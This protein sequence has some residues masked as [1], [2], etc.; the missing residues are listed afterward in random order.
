ML[1]D[2]DGDRHEMVALSES[3]DAPEAFSFNTEYFTG[4]CSGGYLHPYRTAYRLDGHGIPERRLRERDWKSGEDTLPS[5]FERRMRNH[6][7]RDIEISGRCSGFTGRTL[8][9]DGYDLP[10]IDTRGDPH[11]HLFFTGHPSR[12]VT[13]LAIFLVPFPFPM[14]LL[15]LRHLGECPQYAPYCLPDLTRP[16]AFLTG[17]L[18]RTLLSS[19][20]VTFRA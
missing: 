4:L 7:D 17:N 3:P 15:T 1:R 8:A 13:R 11:Q 19:G 9:G 18:F 20:T 14:T 2:D 5:T 16:P 10:V 12:S 6:V